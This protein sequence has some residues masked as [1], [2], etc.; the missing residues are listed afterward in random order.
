MGTNPMRNDAITLEESR[1]IGIENVEDY[2]SFHE[3]HRVFPAV[4]ENRQHKKIIDLAAGVGC[5]AKRIF[6]S[7]SGEIICNDISPTS[8]RVLRK[9]GLNTVSFNLDDAERTFPFLDGSFDAVIALATIEHLI[10]IDHFMQEIYRILADNG[11]LYISAPN[12]SGLIYLI[13]LLHTGK[14]FHDPLS[15]SSRYEFYAHVRYFTYRS[16]LEYVS[17]FGFLPNTVYLNLPQ[18]STQYRSLYARSKFKALTFRNSMKILYKFFSP[19]WA[20]DPLICFRKT[21]DKQIHR[22]RKIVL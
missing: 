8:L 4:F 7:Y 3:R 20:S 1:L 21:D 5:V 17:S 19:R 9:M 13:Q 6:D 18:A 14:T 22:L 2:Q 16:L 10:N 15:P 12:Y 11:Y